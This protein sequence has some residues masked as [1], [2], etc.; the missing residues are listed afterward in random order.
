MSDIS[1]GDLIRLDLG[2]EGRGKLDRLRFVSVEEYDSTEGSNT[3][4]MNLQ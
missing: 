3:L 2:G 4:Q 1:V